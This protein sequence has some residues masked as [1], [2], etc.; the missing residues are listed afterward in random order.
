M[1]EQTSTDSITQE[2]NRDVYSL[3]GLP[4]DSLNVE[5]AKA[6]LHEKAGLNCSLVLSTINVNWVITSLTDP[7]FREAIVNSDIVTLDG[8][9]LLW[10]AKLLG[11]PMP[12]TVPGSTLI[13]KI[14]EDKS[15]EN[16]LSIFLFGG[17]ED[18]AMEAMDRINR[19]GGGLRAVGA[20]N[21]GFGTVEEMSSDD[22]IETINDIKP[23]ILL[24]A[25]G[26]KKGTQ[27]IERNRERLNAGII[28]HLGA[29]I[30]FLAGTVQRAPGVLT[31][32][33]M[34]W[35]WR[36]VQEPKLFMRYAHDG[37]ALLGMLVVHLSSWRRFRSWQK[38]YGGKY[39]N[40]TVHYL[41]HEKEITISFGRN[42]RITEDS[43]IR[44]LFSRCVCS[45]KD[46]TLDFQKTEFADG[47]FMGL[48]LILLKHQ[49]RNN[50]TLTAA[51][52]KGRLKRMFES[53]LFTY[54][55]PQSSGRWVGEKGV[56]RYILGSRL[57]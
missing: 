8:K 35:V 20:L 16:P 18:A 10:L 1:I 28:S 27:W 9:P 51:N 45:G 46:I 11:Y 55:K 25:L 19:A 29:T 3:C 31:Y 30:N 37:L 23:D 38:L 57:K 17:E 24:V 2:F 6:L 50:K 39:V 26:A 21:P 48:L 22:I 12:G 53:C 43:T 7:S 54:E 44:E 47:A 52:V 4:V 15:S 34:E 36:I 5:S 13:Q 40:E 14:N 41:E 56:Q 32:L 42:V 33:G 49:Q